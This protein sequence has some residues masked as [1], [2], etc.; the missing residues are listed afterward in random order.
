MDWQVWDTVAP[1]Q[2]YP[3][4]SIC[5][6][7]MWEELQRAQDSQE[8]ATLAAAITALADNRAPLWHEYKQPKAGTALGIL[9][10]N[11]KEQKK[12]NTHVFILQ[13]NTAL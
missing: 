4:E 7:F 6:T 11:G 1:R 12:G 9:W 3:T 8:L 5:C 10:L 2:A 13:R